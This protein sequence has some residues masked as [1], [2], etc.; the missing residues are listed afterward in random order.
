MKTLLLKIILIILIPYLVPARNPSLI[1][2]NNGNDP[3]NPADSSACMANFMAFLDTN[4]IQPNSYHFYDLS[5]GFPN[6][7]L[8]DFGDGTVSTDQNPVHQFS[9]SGDFT[10]CLTITSNNPA[11]YSCTDDNCMLISTPHYF[12]LGGFAFIGDLPINNPFPT[13]DTAIALLYRIN[14]NQVI[15]VDSL[16]FCEL[17]YYWFSRLPEG[18]YLVKV[19]MLPESVHYFNYLPV[20]FENSPTWTSA[21]QIDLSDESI[22]NANVYFLPNEIV[23]GL[24][25][26]VGSVKFENS[27]PDK[28]EYSLS[29]V[30]VILFNQDGRP[31]QSAFTDENGHFRFTNLAFG[32]YRLSADVAGLY[33]KITSVYLTPNNPISN[34]TELR[35]YEHDTFG[36]GEYFNQPPFISGE[37][38]PDPVQDMV[39]ININSEKNSLTHI[40]IVNILG[41]LMAKKMITINPGTE[42]LSIPVDN[43]EKG[44]Y[45]LK[46]ESGNHVIIIIKKFIKE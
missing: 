46:I 31:L 17:G 32:T 44:L 11:G 16:V 3:S 39:N 38:Y 26:I 36:I 8:W 28:L 4:T 40:T 24:G 9:T 21:S 12:D 33:A 10:V 6:S 2:L 29:D 30:E 34:N 35:I 15:P 20:Y 23:P 45:L 1:S 37:L 43:L 25:E 18:K 7:W 27:G 41:Q 14:N 19:V 13:G 42:T 22:F 5:T